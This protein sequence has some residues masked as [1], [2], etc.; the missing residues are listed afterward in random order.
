MSVILLNS[1][2]IQSGLYMAFLA[3]VKGQTVPDSAHS[4]RM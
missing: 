4:L 1:L 2:N 3:A